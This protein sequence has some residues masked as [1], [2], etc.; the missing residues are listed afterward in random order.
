MN[1]IYQ[2][3]VTDVEII[4]TDDGLIATSGDEYSKNWTDSG[5]NR[6]THL[7]PIP[8]PRPSATRWDRRNCLNHVGDFIQ[9]LERFH[10]MRGR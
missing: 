3:K 7:P 8:T 5:G 1:R 9:L 10:R 4:G 6:L 2:G